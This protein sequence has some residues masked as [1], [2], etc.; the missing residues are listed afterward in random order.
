[1]R[2][3]VFDPRRVGDAVARLYERHAERLPE[4][5]QRARAAEM[6]HTIAALLGPIDLERYAEAFASD[7]ELVD[8]PDARL[9]PRARQRTRCCAASRALRDLAAISTRIAD[10][11]ALSSEALLVRWATAGQRSLRR[12]RLGNEFLLLLKFGADG[13][14]TRAE[15]FDLGREAKRSRASSELAAAS[16]APNAAARAMAEFERAWRARDWEAAR[17][18]PT[19]RDT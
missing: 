16:P 6:A 5:P 18:R 10:V 15:H 1:M 19:R 13:R 2:V 11:L 7:V 9:R 14:V 4:G 17:S 8:Q 12:R 3:E